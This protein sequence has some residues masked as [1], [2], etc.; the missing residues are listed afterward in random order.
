MAS[1]VLGFLAR[2][3]LLNGML[4]SIG[5]DQVMTA[6]AGRAVFPSLLPL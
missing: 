1:Q 4:C 2:T 3:L 6:A 5:H